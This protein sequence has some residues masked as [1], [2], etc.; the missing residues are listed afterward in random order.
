MIVLSSILSFLP[1][2]LS[3]F[4]LSIPNYFVLNSLP[5]K[6]LPSFYPPFLPLFLSLKQP[7]PGQGVF[8]TEGL[9]PKTKRQR[10]PATCCHTADLHTGQQPISRQWAF[11]F[12]FYELQ[13]LQTE[14]TVKVTVTDRPRT[15]L[16][17]LGLANVG[18]TCSD[19]ASFI[20]GLSKS[21]Y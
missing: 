3:S 12:F 21:C 1:P 5:P 4:C 11:F 8:T 18:E 17:W 15:A 16:T 9:V 14:V 19:S 10:D 2:S 13:K 20:E 6:S 7:L